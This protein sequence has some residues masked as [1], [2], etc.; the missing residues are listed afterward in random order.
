MFSLA[1]NGL[2]FM[3]AVAHD[4][5]ES[6]DEF[7]EESYDELFD[8]IA[9]PRASQLIMLHH[10]ADLLGALLDFDLSI[11]TCSYDGT[12]VRVTP[13]AAHSLQTLSC[14]VTP[15]TIEERRNRTRIAKYYGR[16]F[17]PFLIEPCCR[18]SS[19]CEN[20]TLVIA[21]NNENE[22]DITRSGEYSAASLHGRT[23]MEVVY[24]R[25]EQNP[26]DL[27]L[28]CCN[29]W[30]EQAGKVHASYQYSY[31]LIERNAGETTEFLR[32]Y[33]K[34]S[35]EQLAEIQK[36]PNEMR[37]CCI[38][39]RRAYGLSLFV[40]GELPPETD[41]VDETLH[42]P[43]ALMLYSSGR[44]NGFF[45]PSFYSGPAFDSS[46]VRHSARSKLEAVGLLRS[47][48]LLEKFRYISKRGGSADG[49]EPRF[50]H[51]ANLEQVFQEAAEL[52]LPASGRPPVGLNPERFISVCQFCSKWLHGYEFG[53][54]TCDECA[55]SKKPA[56]KKKS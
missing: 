45:D 40:Q 11:A 32:R 18:H 4:A 41:T 37:R 36:A 52:A 15:Y 49:Y 47:Q 10:R 53:A 25:Q 3:M 19:Q 14:S 48:S 46:R 16:G 21:R 34:W 6:D 7:D 42:G 23:R 17:R 38:D 24:R 13:R 44:F 55:E 26:D 56:A 35:D 5:T 27:V 43:K 33:N 8:E 54:D 31:A 22:G 30:P 2:S 39:C 29:D 51:G 9:W 12:A 50:T 20:C 28:F 1:K